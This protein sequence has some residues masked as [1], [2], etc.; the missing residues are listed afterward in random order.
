MKKISEV[1]KEE[2]GKKGFSLNDV[3]QATKIKKDFLTAIEEGRLHDL[4]SESYALGFIK[5]YGKFLG[6]NQDFLTPL[7]KRE[8]RKETEDFMPAFRRNQE[9]FRN[10]SFFT[11]RNTFIILIFIIIFSFIF[12]QYGSIFLGPEL[13]IKTPKDGETITGNIVQVTGKTDPYATVLIDNDEVYVGIDGTFKKSIYVFPGE[14]KINIIAKNRFDKET[15]KTITI[16][17]K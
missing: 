6:L 13:S 4:P 2:R 15:D 12:F 10:R 8:Y 7:F 17:V 5:S 9:K 3:E 1:F 16:K 11:A 14:K